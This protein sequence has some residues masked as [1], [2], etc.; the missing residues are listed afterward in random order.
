MNIQLKDTI[1]KNIK[2]DTPNDYLLVYVSHQL[3]YNEY[4]NKE[5]YDCTF[6][7]NNFLSLYKHND[8][9]FIFINNIINIILDTLR[10]NNKNN[11]KDVDTITLPHQ[12]C[13]IK[14][15][16]DIL[17]IIFNN[18]NHHSLIFKLLFELINPLIDNILISIFY[19]FFKHNDKYDIILSKVN[20]L[21]H[22]LGSIYVENY[23]Y[24]KVNV[25]Q[26][27]SLNNL[28]FE[29]SILNDYKCLLMMLYILS[30]YVNNKK[31]C[32]Y[33]LYNE[34]NMVS[35]TN[36]EHKVGI[37]NKK[38]IEI[39]TQQHDD[40]SDTSDTSSN[41]E[42]TDILDITYNSIMYTYSLYLCNFILQP[43]HYKCIQL[44]EDILLINRTIEDLSAR[45]IY[46][47]NQLFINTLV[48]KKKD[49][50]QVHNY[51]YF[52]IYNDYLH[53][54]II[55]LYNNVYQSCLCNNININKKSF[56]TSI[57]FI[58]L[59][60]NDKIH[61]HNIDNV[62]Y[63]LLGFFHI[64]S[65]NKI[66]IN[67]YNKCVII[68]ILSLNKNTIVHYLINK[69]K[70]YI[71]LFLQS[72]VNIYKK[73]EMN[74]TYDKEEKY[75]LRYNI[76]TIINQLLLHNNIT[77]IDNIFQIINI[78]DVL[79]LLFQDVNYYFEYI[80][81][82]IKFRSIYISNN[83]RIMLVKKYCSY[84]K[85]S[86]LL[87]EK[88][89]VYDKNIIYNQNIDQIMINNF[90]TYLDKI[91]NDPVQYIYFNF[92]NINIYFSWKIDLLE[93]I[94]KIYSAYNKDNL[95]CNLF[96]SDSSNY[97]KNVLKKIELFID[98]IN[99][100]NN[101]NNNNNMIKTDIDV[102][103]ETITIKKNN[104]DPALDID[105]PMSDIHNNIPGKF[106]DPILMSIIKHPIIMPDSNM[107]VDKTMIFNHLLLNHTDPF[108]NTYLNKEL[109]LEYN[110][111]PKNIEKIN[112][113]TQEY[114]KYMDS[115]K[116]DSNENINNEQHD[117]DITLELEKDTIKEY[118]LLE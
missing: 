64:L 53:K 44:K 54:N 99:E 51:F 61:L 41:E 103:I 48:N 82:Y 81:T 73:I 118:H 35:Y 74:K 95:F 8:N 93:K 98:D 30:Y 50:E 84:F 7:V 25:Y 102:L 89:I 83:N 100:N 117:S 31:L 116:K 91:L 45:Y 75:I 72:L 4:F 13:R 1:T 90:N 63:I 70:H 106:I 38:N 114:N 2:L 60:Y 107:I 97:N 68:D 59:F 34:R 56:E 32:Y 67:I 58:K 19:Y 115:V 5:T 47:H 16:L 71:P 3:N 12:R 49:T 28:H 66:N 86:I 46:N 109:L 101:N 76:H 55:L 94:N 14:D 42:M 17:I 80:L 52:F 24:N 6:I 21:L 87:L 111:I 85:E 104:Y 22:S 10:T 20:I 40:T 57:S 105:N 15:I 26:D 110:K 113:F 88:C 62:E 108:C 112:I 33:K 79:F 96:L 39:Y 65:N 29:K 37:Y 36:E 69:K 27:Y 11:S 18:K 23:L 77:S 9:D 43:L 92:N 78:S